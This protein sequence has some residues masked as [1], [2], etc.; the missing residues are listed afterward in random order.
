[1]GRFDNA[2]EDRVD[3]GELG[4]RGRFD[5]GSVGHDWVVAYSYF[6]LEKGNAYIAEFGDGRFDT[7]LYNPRY[8]DLP[9]FLGGSGTGTFAGN[10]I[11][12][13]SLNGRTKFNSFALGDTLSLFNEQLLLTLDLRHQTIKID[14]YAYNTRGRT[15]YD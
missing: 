13:P 11:D 8:I 6:Q 5:T 15:G 12:D 4:F 14:E 9:A 7:N 10:D 1:M 2:R 3:T